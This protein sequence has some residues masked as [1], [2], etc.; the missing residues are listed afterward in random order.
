M[1]AKVNKYDIMVLIVLILMMTATFTFSVK[2]NT[3]YVPLMGGIQIPNSCF[4]LT[5]TGYPCPTCGMT[6]SFIAIGHGELS[7][8][9][10]YNFGGIFAYILCLMEIAYLSLKI[11]SRNTSRWIGLVRKAVKL[12]FVITSVVVLISWICT[13]FVYY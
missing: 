6:R 12:Q 11:T 10:K 1:Q 3:S 7:R 8:A 2:S 9:L 13:N 4:I 5:T